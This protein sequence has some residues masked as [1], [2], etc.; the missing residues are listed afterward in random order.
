MSAPE[1]TYLGDSV[2]AE[3][4]GRAIVLT[5]ENGRGP[6]ATIYLEGETLIALGDFF[7]KVGLKLLGA[8]GSD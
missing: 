2:Y 8:T 7:T 4:D 5:V 3:F 1:K 6:E